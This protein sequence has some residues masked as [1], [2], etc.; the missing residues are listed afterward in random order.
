MDV[1][2]DRVL[3]LEARFIEVW[4]QHYSGTNILLKDGVA[5]DIATGDG[6]GIGVRVMENTWGF[7]SSNRAGDI[8]QMLERALGIARH[9]N[10]RVSLAEVPAY[11]D[12][13]EVQGRIAPEKLSVEEKRELLK[14]CY[15]EIED[16]KEVVSSSF[17]YFESVV[18][19]HYANS[20]GA[21]IVSTYPRIALSAS[22]FAKKDANLQF[23]SERVGGTGGIEVIGDPESVARCA[24]E[25]AERLL[26]AKAAPGGEFKV[27]LDPKLAGVFIHEALGHA[28]EADHVLQGESILE[29]KLGERVAAKGV[30][31]YDD[32][33]LPGS[34]GF[35][36][37]DSEGVKAQRRALIE[38]GVL[39]GYLHSRETAAMLGGEPG[40][41]R[42]QNYSY[43][44]IVRM[45]NTYI[46]EGDYGLEEML[47]EVKNGVYLRG[48]RG[49][50]VDPARGVFQFS[51][52]EGFLI[53]GGELTSCIRDV[54]LS[55]ETLEILKK[56]SAIGK[57]IDTSV[58]FC[59]KNEQSVPVGDGG[60]E[61]ATIATVGGTS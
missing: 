41:A 43:R 49:G 9:A 6:L 18:E 47:A 17:S 56:V 16:I 59:G 14:R 30:D 13:V 23:G 1:I 52:E 12:R 36:H 24:A 39:K 11:E 53:E 7:C 32:P 38:G 22:V 5:K 42:A 3:E 8:S 44:P 27:I 35:Y 61:I 37:Y 2:I 10:D 54:S 29:G 45:S 57:D 20:E 46:G 34:F 33:T 25:K 19:T 48:S 51:A 21:R 31:V 50:E 15:A 26:D 55:G 4:V 60:P 28:A 40:N 58:G